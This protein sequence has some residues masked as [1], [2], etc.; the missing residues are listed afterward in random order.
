MITKRYE[1]YELAHLLL[2]RAYLPCIQDWLQEPGT[3]PRTPTV[4]RGRVEEMQERTVTGEVEVRGKDVLGLFAGLR[5]AWDMLPIPQ[6][7]RQM[8]GLQTTP[9]RV[10]HDAGL[11]AVMESH[12]SQETGQQDTRSEQAES[13]T[14]EALN[15]KHHAKSQQDKAGTAFRIQAA[16]SVQAQEAPVEARYL[17]SQGVYFA[18]LHT[19]TFVVLCR[20]RRWAKPCGKS[21][22]LGTGKP[23]LD[24]SEH[25]RQIT[26]QER[27]WVEP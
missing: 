7:P 9:E 17:A 11:D 18:L 24:N 4:R 16:H 23:A 14:A 25:S 10:A 8:G 13:C 5:G 26:S 27:C 6:Y 15:E 12:D 2:S 21:G 3:E 19:C 1:R 22:V 20:R